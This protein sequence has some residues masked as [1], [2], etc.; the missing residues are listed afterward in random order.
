MGEISA[1]VEL[2]NTA[3]RSV[4]ARGLLEESAIRRTTVEGV[5]DTG[6]VMLVLPENV[7]GRLGPR[8]AARGHRHLCGRTQGDPPG[9][10]TGDD[11]YRQ[12]VHDHGM[13]SRAAAQRAP[14]R[15]DRSVNAGPDSRLHQPHGCAASGVA[16][17]SPAQAEV[18][19]EAT[20]RGS[21]TS[22]S[23]PASSGAVRR[24][25]DPCFHAGRLPVCPRRGRHSP[26]LRRP[27]T[28]RR[29]ARRRRRG[30]AV[31]QRD[32]TETARHPMEL[33]KRPLVM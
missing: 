17:Q 30:C 23:S 33:G 2:E 27:A 7:V 5:V 19:P 15:S 9:R 16:G 26:G 25:P 10:R 14:D 11:P 12:P 13:R 28:I 29:E 1:L 6:A 3:D 32:L 18:M 22:S 8:Y 21:R 31:N 20:A 24:R 4:A